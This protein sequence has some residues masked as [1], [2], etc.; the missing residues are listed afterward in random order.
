MLSVAVVG[1]GT[2]GAAA[3]TL[4]ARAGHAV[5]VF[6][7]VADPKSVGAGITLQPTG[8]VALARLG[9]LDAIA[10]RA[11]RIEHLTITRAN[12]KL[13][14][15]LPYAQV[16]PRLYGLGTHRGVLFETLLAA[17]RATSATLRCGVHVVGTDADARGRWVVDDTGARHGPFEL[18]VAADGGEC[19]LH[20][21]AV[22]V[23]TKPYPWGAA[24][25][26]ADDPGLFTDGRVRQIV[27]GCHTMLGFLPTGMPPGRDAPLI[28]LFWS[29]RADR[30]EAWRDAGLAAWRDRVLRL[31]PRAAP[32]LDTI[33]DLRA[34][35]FTRYRDVAM[36]PWHGDRIVFLG[37]AAHAMSPQLGQ[38]ANLALVDA[39]ALA[40]AIA[41]EPDVPRALAAYSRAR[42]R[43][44]AFYQ[45]MTRL[46]TPLFQ[47]DSRVLGWMR[48]RVFPTSRWWRYL[49]YRMVRAMVGI[50]R[51]VVRRPIPVAEILQYRLPS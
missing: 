14:L 36:D 6:E 44:L 2:A 16:D 18:V 37:D 32:I 34:V 22:R 31:E 38:G 1:A 25:L 27:D 21:A 42:R 33:D 15:D 9:L 24:W 43:H 35:R 13:L 19:E 12:G 51:G 48:D 8:Q 45:F 46:L 50:D 47:S 39:V 28:S 30:V 23:R 11:A 49:R 29:M 41:A 17:V 26:V 3:A 10:T 7:R 5:T 40:D 4:L 20:D